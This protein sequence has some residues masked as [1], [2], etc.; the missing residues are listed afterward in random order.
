M[1]LSNYRDVIK[2]TLFNL[3]KT[4]STYKTY[5]FEN[6]LF[7]LMLDIFFINTYCIYPI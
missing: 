1:A 3:Y 6:K 7:N 4:V 2:H 5:L